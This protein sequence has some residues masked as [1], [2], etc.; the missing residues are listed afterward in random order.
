MV[1]LR[2]SNSLVDRRGESH[3]H[4]LSWTVARYFSS[5][6]ALWQL[7]RRLETP[8]GERSVQGRY[9]NDINRHKPH[10]TSDETL[11]GEDFQLAWMRAGIR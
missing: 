7:A 11:L 1:R 4:T 2:G 6:I 5:L 10:T 9:S 3:T 8:R